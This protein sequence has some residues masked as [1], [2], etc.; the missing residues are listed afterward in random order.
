MQFGVVMQETRNEAEAASRKHLRQFRAPDFSTVSA[1][2]CPPHRQPWT[3]RAPAK[4][5]A[6]AAGARQQAEGSYRCCRSPTAGWLTV[7]CSLPNRRSVGRSVQT[8]KNKKEQQFAGGGKQCTR[9]RTTIRRTHTHTHEY[10]GVARGAAAAVV[11]GGHGLRGGRGGDAQGGQCRETI[12][13]R[14]AACD[15]NSELTF[16]FLGIN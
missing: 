6:A 12:E 15:W 9:S 11:P 16:A 4:E 2:K 7:R 3:R 1:K 5:E 13:P 8:S 10:R 14:L